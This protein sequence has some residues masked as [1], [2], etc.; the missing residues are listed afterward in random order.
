MISFVIV[1]PLSSVMSHSYVPATTP[2]IEDVVFVATEGS[3][4]VQE[5]EYPGIPPVG[6]TIAPPSATPLQLTS[7]MV[8]DA[9]N[10]VLGSN[11]SISVGAQ[12]KRQ[13]P[14]IMAGQNFFPQDFFRPPQNPVIGSL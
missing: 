4:P 2:L 13:T 7:D 8:T 10:G 3:G 5:K 11:T 6:N 12:N 1:H 9:V 14:A